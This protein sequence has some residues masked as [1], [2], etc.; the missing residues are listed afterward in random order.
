MKIGIMTF[1]WSNDNYGQLLQCYALQKYLR[2]AGHDA[3]LIRYDSR[4]DQNRYLLSRILMVFNPVKLI[5]YIKVKIKKYLSKREQLKYNREFENFRNEH[6]CCSERIYYSYEELKKNPPDADMYIT[7]SDQVWSL[8]NNSSIRAY[9]LDF[10]D[11]NIKR[12][13]YAAS[14]GKDKLDNRYIKK[15]TPLLQNFDY[16]SVREKS[17][18]AICKQCGVDNA[19][20][21]PD[22]TIL[23]DIEK[24]RNLYKDKT[25]IKPD[26]SY[27]F[28]YI[29][30]FESK[31][32]IQNIYDWVKQKKLEVIYITGSSQHD[33]YEKY[34]ATI[35][36]WIYLLEHAEYVITNS[37][38][39]S[40]FSILF[41]KQFAVI[42]LAK[43]LINKN[44]RLDSLF[45]LF[46]IKNRFINADISVIDIE[47]NWERV[48]AIIK[49]LKN[50]CKLNNVI[51][52]KESGK[53]KS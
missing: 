5:A 16:I 12:I 37:F 46:E 17:G 41:Q 22:P 11:S 39:C 50:L 25:I 7:G 9:F 35:P 24:Y 3:Y 29:L 27:C 19:E 15:I 13:S 48:S 40:V 36:E 18:L 52:M 45:E 30:G 21:V 8:Q 28:L 38:H 4:K 43:N 2:C 32:S 26:K 20:W 42:P 10:G 49:N 23:L 44:T 34:Y 31:F 51:S 53:L 47:I 33:K 14:F 1:W 6:I